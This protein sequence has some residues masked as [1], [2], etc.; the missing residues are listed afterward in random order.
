MV[1]G[2]HLG[3]KPTQILV[4]VPGLVNIE[5]LEV[6]GK[7]FKP[8]PILNIQMGLSII[9]PAPPPPTTKHGAAADLGQETLTSSQ[10][11]FSPEAH[12]NVH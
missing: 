12:F 8:M 4:Q 7:A 2:H 6:S 9:N 3:R 10:S 5:G 1:Q 11:P